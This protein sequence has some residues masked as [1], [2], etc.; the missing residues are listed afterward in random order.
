MRKYISNRLCIVCVLVALFWSCASEPEYKL[1]FQLYPLMD[2][3]MSYGWF[4]FGDSTAEYTQDSILFR[5]LKVEGKSFE[6]VCKMYGTPS[7]SIF[8]ETFFKPES[9]DIPYIYPI[10]YK[11]KHMKLLRAV[12]N[13]PNEKN[14]E[15]LMTLYF[16]LEGDKSKAIYGYQFN[17]SN[18]VP[19]LPV[20]ASDT[21]EVIDKN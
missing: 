17:Y 8:S 4:G 11:K 1:N 7:E 12:W 16:E 3:L 20:A 6:E 9:G 13:I 18:V 14:D 2:S 21:M 19:P 10:T 15:I 5:G